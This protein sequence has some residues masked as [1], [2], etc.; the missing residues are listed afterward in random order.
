[1]GSSSSAGTCN[2]NSSPSINGKPPDSHMASWDQSSATTVAGGECGAE[3]SGKELLYRNLDTQACLPNTIFGEGGQE[4]YSHVPV[5]LAKCS[6]DLRPA[7]NTALAKYAVVLTP[8]LLPSRVSTKDDP[9]IVNPSATYSPMINPTSFIIWNIR[10]GNNP[11]F[12][13]IFRELIHNHNLCMVALVET[14]MIIH[15]G[16]KDEFGF[17]DFLEV[18]AIGRYC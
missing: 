1:M 5:A 16:L 13:R 12:K 9:L 18:P 10:G 17:D 14:R 15:E 6:F 11:T 3:G 8:T 7:V 4:I 2:T